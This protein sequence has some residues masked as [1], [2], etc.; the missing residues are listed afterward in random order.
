MIINAQVSMSKVQSSKEGIYYS[1]KIQN[2]KEKI[3]LEVKMNAEE[4]AAFI[5]GTVQKL[6]VD[7]KMIKQWVAMI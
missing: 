1:I 4:F 7:D 2:R 3:D 6:P 5:T